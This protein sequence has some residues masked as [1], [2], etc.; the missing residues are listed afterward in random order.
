M[1]D[2]AEQYL[3]SL[4]FSE[5]RVRCHKGDLARIEIP[6]A[7]LPEFVAV[8]SPADLLRRRPEPHRLAGAACRF[9]LKA[10]SRLI[11]VSV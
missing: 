11:S 3:R 4:G 8:G 9:R 7:E 6:R 10:N 5:V 2:A 1:I